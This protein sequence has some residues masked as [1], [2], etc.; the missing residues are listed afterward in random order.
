MWLTL[1]HA[2]ECPTVDE[3]VRI[4]LEWPH[5]LSWTQ[6]ISMPFPYNFPFLLKVFYMLSVTHNEASSKLLLDNKIGMSKNKMWLV[7]LFFYLMLDWDGHLAQGGPTTM[8]L[9]GIGTE[10]LWLTFTIVWRWKVG[11][12]RSYRAVII[13]V[14]G[15]AKKARLQVEQKWETDAQRET[16]V[17]D[18]GL[19]EGPMEQMSWPDNFTVSLPVPIGMELYFLSSSCEI[20]TFLPH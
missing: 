16:E 4:N 1:R 3:S 5:F 14:Q 17:R 10:S 2:Q 6:E 20:P 8:S 7:V 15:K 11:R 19:T 9:T 18:C 13:C 12:L